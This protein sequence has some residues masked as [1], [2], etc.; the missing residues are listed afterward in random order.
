MADALPAED[1]PRAARAGRRPVPPCARSRARPGGARPPRR[2]RRRRNRRRGAPTTSWR[3]L[4]PPLSLGVQ[5]HSDAARS[6]VSATSRRS[7]MS[8]APSPRP[9]PTC[10]HG[11]GAKGGAFARLRAGGKQRSAS[12][13]RTAARC[14]T[15]ASRRRAWSTAWP[16]AALMRRTDLFLF[17]SAFARDAFT[18]Q[19]RH[20]ARAS[21]RRAQ[22]RQRRRIRSRSSP[23]P[24]RATS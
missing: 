10:V 23:R 24:P 19:D 11:H 7:A 3:A 21:S 4:A 2:H 16:S 20:A 22:R 17:E 18:A 9:H 1:P 5:P 12:T 14:I 6:S 15:A 13:R 8:R